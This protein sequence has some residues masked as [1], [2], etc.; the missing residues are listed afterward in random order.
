[1]SGKNLTNPQVLKINNKD[2]TEVLKFRNGKNNYN[3]ILIQ[4]GDPFVMAGTILE[5]KSNPRKMEFLGRNARLDALKRHDPG[6]IIKDLLNVYSE[7]F[8]GNTK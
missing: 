1:M 4:A 3:G 2:I 7:I 5:L 6:E 8:Y